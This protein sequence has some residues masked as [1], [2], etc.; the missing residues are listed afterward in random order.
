MGTYNSGCAK[1]EVPILNQAP[2]GPMLMVSHAN[3]NPGL[4]KAWDPGEPDKYYPT[5]KRNYARVVTTDDYQGAAAA[6][7]A[8]KDLSVKT[9]LRPQ[10]QPDLRPG[11][12]EGVP[13]EAAKKNG[14]KI[15]GNDAV[16]RQAAEL[17]R[18]V[19]EDQGHEPRLR[20]PRR[21]LRQQRWPA[22]SRTRSAV[23]GD[24]SKVKLIGPDGFTG[25][26][27]LQ[28]LSRE[29]QG[30]YLTFAGLSHRRR[31][32]GAVARAP[33]CS[34][35]TRPSTA[36]D[37]GR[38]LRRSTAWRR[39]RSSSQAHREVRRHPPGRHRRRCSAAPGSRSR[40][41]SRSSARRS[42]HRPDDR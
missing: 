32:Q 19:P 25:Y 36:S 17:H 3:T 8:A 11:C 12:R 10:R 13:D 22:A 6:Q 15:L 31:C 7:F 29:A 20:L 28:K 24:N 18:A 39:C 27:D 14:I 23:L 40:P 16:G 30:M 26:P 42:D 38:Q 21:H 33:S 4:T 34:T 1:I 2:G 9:V 41:T 37:S 5:G 35:P